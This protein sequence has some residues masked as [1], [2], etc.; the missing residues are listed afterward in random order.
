MQTVLVRSKTW[1]VSLLFTLLITLC[2]IKHE[3]N[4]CNAVCTKGLFIPILCAI[5]PSGLDNLDHQAGFSYVGY[6]LYSTYIVLIIFAG[7]S[8]NGYELYSGYTS[9][10]NAW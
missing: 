6:W 5:A 7:F 1:K 3:P 10:D 4:K 9:I 8:C 2:T